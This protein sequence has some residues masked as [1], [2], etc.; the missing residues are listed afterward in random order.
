MIKRSV[1]VVVMV[2][3]KKVVMWWKNRIL[4]MFERL[5]GIWAKVDDEAS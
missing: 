4:I 1:F 2:N 3:W 5:D